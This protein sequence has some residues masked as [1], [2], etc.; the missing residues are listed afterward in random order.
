V[1]AL[2]MPGKSRRILQALALLGRRNPRLCSFVWAGTLSKQPN[3]SFADAAFLETMRLIRE[4]ASAPRR[5]LRSRLRAITAAPGICISG[6][7]YPHNLRRQEALNQ[8]LPA[9]R[10]LSCV[11][12]L[13]NERERFYREMRRARHDRDFSSVSSKPDRQPL[14]VA[15]D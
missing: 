14:P 3:G 1:L 11:R 4:C 5:R 2:V 6:G 12:F 7:I 15:P 13:A 9:R 10:S 8:A